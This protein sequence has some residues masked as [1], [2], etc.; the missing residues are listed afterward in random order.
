MERNEIER[1]VLDVLGTILRQRFEAGAGISRRNTH[2]WDSLRH[3][4]IMFALEDEFGIEFSEEELA[5]LE[6]VA[7]IVDAVRVRHAP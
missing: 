2:A 7:K 4:E 6:S 5:S 1:T 3:I